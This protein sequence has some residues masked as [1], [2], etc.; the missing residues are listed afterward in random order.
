M[1]THFV[2]SSKSGQKLVL[3]DENNVKY[4]YVCVMK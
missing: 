4:A 3:C 2:V 1:T